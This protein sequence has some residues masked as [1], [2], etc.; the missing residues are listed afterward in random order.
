L[1]QKNLG[2]KGITSGDPQ[3][4]S[5]QQNSCALLRWFFYSPKPSGK[6]GLIYSRKF[7]S[8]LP[9]VIQKGEAFSK[10]PALCSGGFFILQSLQASLGF[11]E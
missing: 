11:E 3:G 8:G 6:L 5:F 4:G 10:T 1:Q 7:Y 9:P 2:L